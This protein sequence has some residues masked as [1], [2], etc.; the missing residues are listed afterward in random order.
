MTGEATPQPLAGRLALITGAGRGI[1]AAVAKRFAAEGAQ[2]ILVSRTQGALEALDDELREAGFEPPTLVP[3]DLEDLDSIDRMATSVAQ[4]FGHVDILVAN[5]A[6][7]GE[8]TPVAHMD[9]D[10]WDRVLRTNLTANW[11]LIRA[12]DP[13]LRASTAG[14]AMFVTSG[15]ATSRRAFWGAYAASKSGLEALVQVY[16]REME[17][18]PVRI[19]L[20]N[21]GIVR[22]RMRATAIPGEDPLTL[23]PPEAIT[24]TFV[25]LA[26]PD[27]LRNGEIVKAQN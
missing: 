4:R 2:L 5:A 16:A 13:L 15:I 9:P 23:P 26:L 18:T 22:T 3:L 12:F 24:D 21:P 17:K 8:L 7:L 14:R 1:G 11:R 10:M 20:V 19:N 25:E 6:I 27:C